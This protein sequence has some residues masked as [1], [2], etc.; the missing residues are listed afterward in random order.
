MIQMNVSVLADAHFQGE[1]TMMSRWYCRGLAVLAST[2]FA[3]AVGQV[4]P[5]VQQG[6]TIT[7]AAAEKKKMTQLHIALQV[8]FSDDTVRI[9][10]DGRAV[11]SK[12]GVT[13]PDHVGLAD[14]VDLTLPTGSRKIVVEIPTRR[15]S[16]TIPLTLT[17]PTYLGILLSKE[18]RISSQISP[19]PFAYM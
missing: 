17:A 14:S 15:T 11:F 4:T 10:I 9:V 16:E 6:R 2:L 8:G 13:T 19:R 7:V 18:G 5:G 3:G 1:L 12:A